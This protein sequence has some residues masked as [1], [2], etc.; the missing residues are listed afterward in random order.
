M[1]KPLLK[2]LRRHISW[3]IEA[4]LAYLLIGL[5]RLL[6]VGVSSGVMGFIMRIIGP[7]TSFH[8]RS[9]FNISFA[10][11]EKTLQERR[12]IA[13][14]M[15]DNL[16]RVVGEFFH[17][18]TIMASKRITV[19]GMEHI[20]ALRDKG[21]FMISAHIGNWE[22]ASFPGVKAGFVMN[23]VYRPVNNPYISAILSVCIFLLN[24]KPFVAQ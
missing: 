7:L 24:N 1:M 15:W 17:I 16:G 9:L 11:P 18:R 22:L 23:C 3:P 13:R 21:G 4:V 2:F 6:P 19:H 5:L 20:E 8:R 10:M 14:D 12:K